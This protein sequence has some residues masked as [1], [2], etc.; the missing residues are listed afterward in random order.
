VT[1]KLLIETRP[2]ESVLQLQINRPKVMN[3]LNTAVLSAISQRLEEVISDASIRAVV[4]TGN[5]RAFAAGADIDELQQVATGDFPEDERQAAWRSLREFPKPLIAAVSG[6]A[7]GGGCELMMVADI[8]IAA[9]TTQLGQPEINLGIMPGAGGTVR[10]T[11]LVGKGAAMKLNLTGEFIHATEALKL[12]LVTEV[13]EPEMYLSRAQ[14]I[15]AKI[16]QKSTL[17]AQAIK[18]SILKCDMTDLEQGLAL[19]REKFLKLA[20][21]EDAAE[22]ISAFVEK[23]KPKFTSNE[24]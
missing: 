17:A 9:R 15:A 16:A 23:R 14:Q 3:A 12:G 22:G 5:D 24:S 2:S 6:Y 19:E 1:E 4:L 11:R 21:S 20:R 7:L 18:A 10:L 13:V 8:V